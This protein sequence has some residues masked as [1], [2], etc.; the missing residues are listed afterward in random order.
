[1]ENKDPLVLL[2][3]DEPAVLEKLERS[4]SRGL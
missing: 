1:M 2:V 4:G 3:G